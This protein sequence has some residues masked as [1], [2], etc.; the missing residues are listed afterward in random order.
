VTPHRRLLAARAA[1]VAIVLLATLT[2]LQFSPDLA[3]AAHRLARAFTPSLGWRDAI[4][5]VR[6]IALFAGLGTV[7][8]V[9]SLSGKVKDEIARATLAAFL[10]SA[11]VEGLQAFSPVRIS[12]IVD[13][14]TNTL[15]GLGGAAATGVLVLLVRQA[16]GSRSYLGMPAFVL[17]VSYGGAM[18][19]EAL[20]PLFRSDP[21]S[22]ISG[23]PLSRLHTM[24][25]LS[26]PLSFG[27]LPLLDVALFVPA[28][29]LIV[30]MV[31]ETGRAQ[32][33]RTWPIVFAA[34]VPLLFAAH[35]AHGLFGVP[36]RWE[37]AVTDALSVGFGAWLADR[38]LAPLTQSLRGPL[39]ARAALFAYAGLLVVWGWR[40]LLP[41]FDLRGTLA[42]L[43]SAHLVPLASLAE[44]ADV[45]SALHVAQQFLLYVPLGAL[46]A[47]WPLRL[48]GRWAHLWPALWLAALIELGHLVIAERYFD[49]TNALLAWAGLG[50]GWIVL[51]RCGYA[52]YGE[53][54]PA[55]GRFA[56]S[57]R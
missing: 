16:K 35:V 49:V 23:G 7:W 45:F 55:P 32:R 15:G 9:T 30:M 26:L 53:V 27:E 57:A 18:L 25:L 37:A 31:G 56:R 13:V 19:C 20:T 41:V 34:A 42:Q 12:S 50:I 22:G 8:V 40:P 29:F 39:R 24:M 38:W 52:P 43:T 46:L 17:A 1:Y 11:L 2:D 51:R 44:R 10:L 47:V 14:T 36:V 54:L 3:E 6:N 21:L 33:A 5:G 28:G 4:D 48:K